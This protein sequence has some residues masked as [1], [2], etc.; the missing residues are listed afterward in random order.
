MNTLIA[1]G[2]SAAYFASAAFLLLPDL[3]MTAMVNGRM[4]VYFDTSATIVTLIL[5]GRFL[6]ARA[7]SHTSD[8]IK[9]LI[10]L[11]PRTA[12]VVRDGVEADL[13]IEQVVVGDGIVVRPGERVGVVGANAAGKSTVLRTLDQRVVDELDRGRRTRSFDERPG[14]QP[15][16]YLA[17]S[18]WVMVEEP[19]RLPPGEL[20]ALLRRA[21]DE[22]G[23]TVIMVTHDASAAAIAD[24]IVFLRD[25]RI[26]K[27]SGG[28]SAGEILDT[29][30]TYSAVDPAARIYID[31]EVSFPNNHWGEDRA[32]ASISGII[33]IDRTPLPAP[34]PV[35]DV[36][37]AIARTEQIARDMGLGD[38]LDGKA[39]ERPPEE[40]PTEQAAL[41][42]QTDA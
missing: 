33:D 40:S 25:G 5:L 13:P 7:R 22:F 24:R 36:Q 19:G 1:V 4:A 20:R 35:P 15:A 28:L 41:E 12:R 42:V 31:L 30:K 23:Q 27:D 17:R 18:H 8:A 3:G 34:M 11:Q 26:V 32:R 14:F 21:V 10:G 29:I 39:A 38:L 9:A 16:P 37:Q 2:T 6:E